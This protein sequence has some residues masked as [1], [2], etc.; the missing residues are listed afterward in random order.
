M[1]RLVYVVSFA[2]YQDRSSVGGFDWFHCPVEATERY[3]ELKKEGIDSLSI[4]LLAV[5]I[6]PYKKASEITA[7]IDRHVA[8]VETSWPALREHKPA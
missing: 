5:T 6:P 1:N 7:Y 4:R 3:Y 8:E 2:P